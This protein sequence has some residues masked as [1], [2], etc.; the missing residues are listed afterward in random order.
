MP[1]VSDTHR[2]HPILSAALLLAALG[3]CAQPEPAEAEPEPQ[4]LTHA[5]PDTEYLTSRSPRTP[6]APRPE[7]SEV[8]HFT[9]YHNPAHYSAHPR[10]CPFKYLGH[11]EIILGCRPYWRLPGGG[12][13]CRRAD[14]GLELLNHTQVRIMFESRRGRMGTIAAKLTWGGST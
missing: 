13:V 10:Q 5:V 9:I 7:I 14:T 8:E 11:D 6:L 2:S 1:V 4:A 12:A 3:A